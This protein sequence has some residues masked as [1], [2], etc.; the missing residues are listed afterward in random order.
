[1]QSVH[2]IEVTAQNFQTAVVEQS[3][4]VPVLL[5]FWA[6]WCQPCRTLGPALEKL[7]TEY[8]G[9]F[10]LGKVNAEAEYE[11]SAAFQ[12]RSIPFVVVIDQGRPVDGFTG[13]LPE[14][15]LRRFLKRVGVEPVRKLEEDEKVDPKSPA[16]RLAAATAALRKG[17]AP[18][19]RAALD[20][21]PADDP[22]SDIADR[23]RDGLAWFE[24]APAGGA[25]AEAL[26]R[27]RAQFLA[28]QDQQALESLL[29][30]VAADKGFAEGLARRA[31]LAVFAVL[32]EDHDLSDEYRRRLTTLL[33]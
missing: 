26:A 3:M 29:A 11:L 12:V 13:A 5:D 27:G 18:G 10:V 19:A 23:L 14:A 2:V 17:D 21:F 22:S 1:M 24:G 28:G 16:G 25:A 9:S 6:D 7:A 32:G 8:G 4:Q 15:E 33:Y 31:M 20:G 30:S